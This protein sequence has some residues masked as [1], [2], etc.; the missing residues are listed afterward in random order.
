MYPLWGKR[1]FVAK[2]QGFQT[3]HLLWSARAEQAPKI[4]TTWRAEWPGK[5]ATVSRVETGSRL[6]KGSSM[7]RRTFAHGDDDLRQC[8]TAN[9]LRFHGLANVLAGK[10]GLH[11]V[12]V[13]YGCCI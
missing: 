11:V 5:T 3:K 2:S 8:A 4:N 1:R 7:R 9:E 6:G 13:S 12:D 10:V